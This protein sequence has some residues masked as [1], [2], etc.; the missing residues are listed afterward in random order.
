TSDVV[1]SPPSPSTAITP[2]SS[3]P[4]TAE[5]G[6]PP[7]ALPCDLRDLHP[8]AATKKRMIHLYC[9]IAT[10]LFGTSRPLEYQDFFVPK[11]TFWAMLTPCS[12]TFGAIASS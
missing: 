7:S 12:S 3:R 10:A 11:G 8:K 2:A 5:V 1:D 6:S 4:S 9:C